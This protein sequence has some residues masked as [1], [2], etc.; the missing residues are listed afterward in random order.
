MKA[1]PRSSLVI[2][3]IEDC[4]EARSLVV[5]I[6]EGFRV[7]TFEDGN[8]ALKWLQSHPQER[9]DLVISDF[10][11]PGPNGVEVLTQIRKLRPAI[12]TVLMSATIQED[13]QNVVTRNHFNG[14]LEKPFIPSQVEGLLSQVLAV[15]DQADASQKPGN[16]SSSA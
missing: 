6:L 9:V 2:M 10:N 3:A 4:P 7:L 16:G 12:K 15:P 13:L 5:E 11:M 8:K 14:F 1:T